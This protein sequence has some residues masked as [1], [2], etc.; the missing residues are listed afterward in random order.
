MNVSFKTL[1]HLEDNLRMHSIFCFRIFL[2]SNIKKLYFL[3]YILDYLPVP[4][5][6]SKTSQC[7]SSSGSSSVS[8][9]SVLCSVLNVSHVTLSWFKGNR[10]FSS[11][12]ASD[13][14]INLSL[15]LEVEHQ[16][17]NTYSC[18]LNNNISNQTKHLDIDELCPPCA[19][20][21]EMIL[22][23]IKTVLMRDQSHP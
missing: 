18:V 17:K 12:S 22:V 4:V 19:G 14:S 2:Q 1:E 21:S 15:P 23:F 11:I 5:I 10:L 6:I 16:D 20:T 8:K 13:L 9:C 7:C 3:Y